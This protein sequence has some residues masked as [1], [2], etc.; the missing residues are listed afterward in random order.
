MNANAL[1]DQKILLKYLKYDKCCGVLYWKDHWE[2]NV[3]SRMVGKP[4]LFKDSGGY[5]RFCLNGAKYL[6]HRIVYFL[7]TGE[8]PCEIDH[9]DGDRCNNKFHNL[10]A[11][12]SR[13]NNINKK[14]HRSGHLPGA[15]RHGNKWISKIVIDYEVLY[16]GLFS[17][18]EEA[19]S[20]YMIFF[21]WVNDVT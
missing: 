6:V 3:K 13:S 19:H 4:I 8:Q 17:S 20:V 16:L 14:I 11:S 9:I 18:Q 21:N 7:E 12:S 10:R 5:L 2:E 15:S 1:P